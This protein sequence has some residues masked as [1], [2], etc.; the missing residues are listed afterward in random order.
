VGEEGDDGMSPAKL[1]DRLGVDRATVYRW[2]RS[3]RIRAGRYPSGRR[4]VPQAEVDRILRE[5]EGESV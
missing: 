4:R 1:A 5:L 2:I 3:G